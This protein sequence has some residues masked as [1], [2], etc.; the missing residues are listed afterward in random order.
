MEHQYDYFLISRSR[1]SAENGMPGLVFALGFHNLHLINC[2]K[3]NAPVLNGL[4]RTKLMRRRHH[5][6]AKCTFNKDSK[7]I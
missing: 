3:R 5:N 6:G 7:W 4:F 2:K 1:A